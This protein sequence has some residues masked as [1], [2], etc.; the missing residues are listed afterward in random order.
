VR[1]TNNEIEIGGACYKNHGD[2]IRILMKR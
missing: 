1:G 2:D